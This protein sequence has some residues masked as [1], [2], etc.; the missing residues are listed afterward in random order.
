MLIL[1]SKT[2]L[3]GA[4]EGI[5]LCIKSVIPSL[6]PFFVLSSML[7][8]SLWGCRMFTPLAR[9]CGLPGGSGSVLMVGLLG[10][11]PVGAQNV[12]RVYRQG[13]LCKS[14]AERML[15]F[16]SNAGPS[17]FFGIV[18]ARFSF[19]WAGIALWGIHIFSALMVASLLPG[20]PGEDITLQERNQMPLPNALNESIKV[21]ANVCGWVILFRVILAFLERW[22]LW[23]LSDPLRIS[24]AGFLE[25]A[26]GCCMLE[27]IRDEH[28]RFVIASGLLGIGGICVLMQTIA[29]TKGLSIKGYLLGK[30]LQALFSIILSLVMVNAGPW[31]TCALCAAVFL[32]ANLK[33][34]V[35][36]PHSLV[37]N[38]KKSAPTGGSYAVP[39][40]N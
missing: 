22:L 4:A 31:I 35:E 21:M 27:Q 30:L 17:F 20:V 19:W 18:A 26:N 37:Y 28:L 9:L 3:A 23:M 38:K 12:S 24:I 16:C 11:Y 34:Y 14:Q 40:E 29:V 1:D 13:L 15:S 5:E 2:G 8:S 33:K 32:F 39:K 6:F 7:T 36:I 25:L 10:G